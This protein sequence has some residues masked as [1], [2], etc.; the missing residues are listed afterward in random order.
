MQTPWFHGPAA[1]LLVVDDDAHIR[2]L[3]RGLLSAQGYVVDEA[4]SAEE[5]METFRNSSPDLVILDIELPRRSGHDV[6]QEIRGASST[7]LVPVIMLTGKGTRQD[8][9]RAW[10]SG[11]T[12]FF[13]KPFDAEELLVRVRALVQLKYFTDELEEAENVIIALAKTIDARDPYTAGHSDRVSYYAGRLGEAIGLKGL[14]LRAVQRGGLFHDLGKIAV[15]DEI[16]LK[17]DRLTTDE[18]AEMKR[19]PVVGRNL[20]CHMRSME[21][22]LQVVYHHHEKLDGSGY[23]E[24]LSGEGIPLAARVT[25]IADIYDALTTAR[26]YRGALTQSEALDIMHA[27]ARKGWWDKHL[28]RVFEGVLEKIEAPKTMKQKS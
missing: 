25:S 23:P 24:G 16:L 9:L 3:L 4:G 26:V 27:E 22:G 28:L 5:A 8:R 11:V 21:Y 6:L 2:N 17:N 1:R 14:D 13:T 20:L 15:R 7:R 19:H 12:D 18:Y 10:K